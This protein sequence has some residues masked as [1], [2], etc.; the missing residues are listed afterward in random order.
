MYLNAHFFETNT[1]IDRNE[2]SKTKN[3]NTIYYL[4]QLADIGIVQHKKSFID[5]YQ[6]A[7]KFEHA[8]ASNMK[9]SLIN[10]YFGIPPT[11]YIS[12]QRNQQ[13]NKE[14]QAEQKIISADDLSFIKEYEFCH[15][16]LMKYINE[17]LFRK[18]ICRYD[19][20][21]VEFPSNIVSNGFGMTA[22]YYLDIVPSLPQSNKKYYLMPTVDI[23]GFFPTTRR[24][25]LIIDIFASVGG[26]NTGTRRYPFRYF[27]QLMTAYNV[28]QLT[29]TLSDDIREQCIQNCKAYDTFFI[30]SFGGKKYHIKLSDIHVH[31]IVVQAFA[32]CQYLTL[33]NGRKVT[34]K[35]N[36]I[37]YYIYD[38]NINDN[39][40]NIDITNC[41][42]NDTHKV[43]NETIIYDSIH[44]FPST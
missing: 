38:I 33:Y 18:K 35:N 5:I 9:T 39:N 34:S 42:L 21:I 28:N 16:L 36:G 30:D 4:D 2:Q 25:P 40:D 6:D 14:R 26:Y 32:T 7:A 15:K 19:C 13:E 43:A 29:I 44:N 10:Q 22:I 23:P 20:I 3:S 12:Y 1:S 17:H 27:S 8:K 24:L 37:K 41:K 11:T 31:P